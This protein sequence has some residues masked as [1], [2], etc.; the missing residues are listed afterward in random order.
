MLAVS[1]VGFDFG[2]AF[3]LLVVLVTV[4]FAGLWV[5]LIAFSLDYG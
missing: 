3:D 4:V 5:G 1:C 2:V